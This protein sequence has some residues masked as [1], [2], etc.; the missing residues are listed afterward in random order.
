MKNKHAEARYKNAKAYTK[1]REND[2]SKYR[3]YH[4]YKDENGKPLK[5]KGYWDDVGVFSGSIF[6][7][8][9]WVHPRYAFEE[10]IRHKSYDRLYDSDVE[11]WFNSFV[12]QYK[13]VGKSR[14]KVVSYQ[15]PDIEEPTT[16]VK[17][18]KEAFDEE[19]AETSYVQKCF[20]KVNMYKTSRC[21]EVCYP[22]E[23]IN[24]ESLKAMADEVM[25]YI[26]DYSKFYEKYGDF[27]Y[28]VNEYKQ[29]NGLL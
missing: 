1:T 4:L 15:S 24:E 10:E 8:I 11:K 9:C 14:K 5:E 23:V 3:V 20:I 22:I 18:H 13:K 27:V 7:S 16:P 12:P 29:E 6:N 21:I 26:H 19:L 25:G 28:G 17:T 2:G